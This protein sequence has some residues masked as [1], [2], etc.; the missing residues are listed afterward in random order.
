MASVR[1][2]WPSRNTADSLSISQR[3]SETSRDRSRDHCKIRRDV[4]T[5]VLGF[6][7][8]PH[9]L[10]S[11]RLCVFY[12]GLWNGLWA[13]LT[14]SEKYCA[15]LQFSLKATASV[16]KPWYTSEAVHADRAGLRKQFQCI[17]VLSVV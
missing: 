15:N 7:I 8:E 2:Q 16:Q 5:V 3:P 10:W 6:N 4:E 13:S 17:F 12:N 9:K 1:K 11:L 14:A